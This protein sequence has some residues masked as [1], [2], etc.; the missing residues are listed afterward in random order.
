[1][2]AVYFDCFAGVSGDMIIGAQLDLGVDL[3]SMEQQLSSLGLEGYQ[4][5]RRRVERSG[6]SATKFDVEVNQAPAPAWT[7]AD[8][9][10]IIIGSN[11]TEHVKE[12]AILVF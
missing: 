3:E 5:N 12:Q 9:R 1:M 10:S 6:I 2:R 8:I 4:I 7:L 11:A